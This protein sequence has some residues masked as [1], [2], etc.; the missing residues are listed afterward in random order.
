MIPTD[1]PDKIGTITKS[2]NN[3]ISEMQNQRKGYPH[4]EDKKVNDHQQIVQVFFEHE[5]HFFLCDFVLI[6]TFGKNLYKLILNI[7]FHRLKTSVFTSVVRTLQA[8]KVGLTTFLKEK[9]INQPFLTI[10]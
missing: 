7:D 1:E 4:S 10:L 6:I 3:R 5:K 2:T 8:L 9:F